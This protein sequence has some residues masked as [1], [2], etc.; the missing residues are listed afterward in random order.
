[1]NRLLVR[2]LG[3]TIACGIVGAALNALPGGTMVPLLLGRAVTLPI[4]ILF[5]PWL[6]GVAAVIGGLALV[7][8]AIAV[9]V[10]AVL[11]TE[12]VLVGWFSRRGRSPIIAGALVWCGVAV[13]LIAAPQWFG[14]GSTRQ[15]MLPIAL[16]M[17]L[18]GL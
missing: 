14:N 5:G 18:S 4:A 3:L 8:S 15:T 16:Q 13:L 1:M 10:M 2:R 9:I 12:A 17:P 11:L 6:G 7:R